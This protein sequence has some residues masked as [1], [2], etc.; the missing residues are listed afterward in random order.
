M[1]T[2]AS[3]ARSTAASTKW[4]VEAFLGL[5]FM[6]GGVASVVSEVA[7]QP[8]PAPYFGAA[9]LG[10]ATLATYPFVTGTLST[11]WLGNYLLGFLGVLLVLLAAGL[12]TVAFG[13]ASTDAIPSVAVV[14]VGNVAGVAVAI[15]ADD[16]LR[17]RQLADTD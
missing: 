1:A 5:A 15:L 4:F 3:R 17:R 6:L 2:L 8:L 13:L 11:E 14:A 9:A 10:I 16:P 12:A 7:G